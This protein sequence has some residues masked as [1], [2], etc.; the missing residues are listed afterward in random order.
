VSRCGILRGLAERTI[1]TDRLEIKSSCE[2]QAR[3]QRWCG[4]E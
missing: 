4:R 2:P 3:A 1:E